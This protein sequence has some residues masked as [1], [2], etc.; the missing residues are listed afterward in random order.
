M[1]TKTK[2]ELMEEIKAKN[3]EIANLKSE[4][5]KLDRYKKYEELTNELAAIRDSF[6][7]SGFSESE[8]YDMVKSFMQL[9]IPMAMRMR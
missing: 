2:A 7:K 5:E 4:V 8:A 3:Q 6:V 1:A 9:T